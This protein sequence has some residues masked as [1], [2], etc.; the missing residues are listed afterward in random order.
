[1]NLKPANHALVRWGQSCLMA[2]S[3]D[4]AAA[5]VEAL[6]RDLA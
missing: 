4:G 5:A 1:M 6:A 2:S 3:W